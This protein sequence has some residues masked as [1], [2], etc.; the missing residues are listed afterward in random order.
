MIV[1][2]HDKL[3]NAHRVEATRVV[4]RDPV[5][6]IMGLAIET[7]PRHYFLIHRGEGDVAM[8]R[9][10]EALGINETVVTDLVTSEDFPKPPGE[11]WTPKAGA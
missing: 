11:L 4:L 2:Y 8:N 6:G 9:A 10:L 5:D 3:G 7:A 1:E